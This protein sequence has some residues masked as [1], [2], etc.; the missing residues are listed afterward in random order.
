MTC[1]VC[2]R[3]E[4]IRECSRNY[5][6]ARGKRFATA[7]N[8][9]ETFTSLAQ[10]KTSSQFTTSRGKE[11]KEDSRFIN[12]VSWG[13]VWL[14]TAPSHKRIEWERKQGWG[15]WKIKRRGWHKYES[16]KAKGGVERRWHRSKKSVR[17]TQIKSKG[18][19]MKTYSWGGV[20]C[21]VRYKL[22]EGPFWALLTLSHYNW[23]N[24]ENIVICPTIKVYQVRYVLF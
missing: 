2:P 22:Q 9:K 17:L 19:L 14:K 13:G 21:R 16:K 10:D 20:W 24:E 11:L 15:W 1:F 23:R 12:D 7:L 8:S 18:K 5:R 6:P 3:D 4:H